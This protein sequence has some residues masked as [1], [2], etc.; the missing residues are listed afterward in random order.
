MAYA[1]TKDIASDA[2]F[3][4]CGFDLRHGAVKLQKSGTCI[5]CGY[6]GKLSG[7]HVFGDWLRRRFDRPAGNRTHMLSRPEKPRFFEDVKL[8]Q[9]VEHNKR[10]QPYADVVF[11]V[12]EE[13]N[14]NWMSEV[15]KLAAP[16]VSRLADG[17]WPKL[18][19]DEI[20]ALSRWVAMVAINL[21]SKARIQTSTQSHRSEMMAGKMPPGWRISAARLDTSHY[22]G[23]SRHSTIK[24]PIGIGEDFL[25][26]QITYF[27]VENVA[28]H[29]TSTIGDSTL[30]LIQYAGVAEQYLPRRIWPICDPPN[31]VTKVRVNKIALDRMHETF[32][33]PF[34]KRSLD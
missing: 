31:L 12:C 18:S 8:V 13:C 3:C 4:T 7:E 33:S 23:D 28:F 10:A 9:N 32:Q 24:L 27:C 17:F 1:L 5:Y 11:N 16:V 6:R 25:Q 26:A 19:E 21:E 30:Q 34:N 20:L 2:P 29:A 14:N 22:G 15:H